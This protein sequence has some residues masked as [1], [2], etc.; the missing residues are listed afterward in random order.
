MLL[1]VALFNGASRSNLLRKF[2]QIPEWPKGSDCKSDGSRLRRFESFSAHHVSW[3]KS[4]GY[5]GFEESPDKCDKQEHLFIG[6]SGRPEATEDVMSE[7]V[8]RP[9][10]EAE[11][12]GAESFSAHQ[13]CRRHV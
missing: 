9:P 7:E 12:E 8:P 4:V 10:D 11:A 3:K 2:G 6:T 1:F 13:T 5:K